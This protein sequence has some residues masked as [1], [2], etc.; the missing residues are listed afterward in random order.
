MQVVGGQANVV[1]TQSEDTHTDFDGGPIGAGD[2]IYSAFD[3]TVPAQTAAPNNVYFAHFKDAG[4]FFGSRVWITGPAVAG[5]GYRLGITG[6]SS[7]ETATDL[8]PGGDLAFGTTYRVVTKYDFDTGESRLWVN[9]VNESST[10][11]L[12]DDSFALDGFESYS[13]RESTANST[14]FIDNLCVA[15]AFGQ[16]LRCVPEPSSIAMLLLAGFAAFGF[17]RSGR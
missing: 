6:D 16:A 10:N 8:W 3:L 17:R 14:S 4:N 12:S 11:A 5:N 13:L 2:T 7:L 1:H 9:P 15:T